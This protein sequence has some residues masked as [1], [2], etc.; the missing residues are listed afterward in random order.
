MGS[1]QQLEI[2][3]A[4]LFKSRQYSKVVFEIMSETA[5]EERSAFL[6]NL[7]GL[8]KIANNNKNKEALTSAL[9]DFK[10]GYLKEKET[11]HAIDGLAN[12]ITSSVFLIDLEKNYEFDFTEILDFYN[13]SERFCKNHRSIHL[14]MAMVY[15]RLN[16]AKKLI[17]HF[18]KVIESNKYNAIDLCNYG[19]WQC[20]DKA[21]NQ[22]D[23]FNYGKFLD[24][25]LKVFTRDQLVEISQASNSKIRIGF[26]S[27]DI[28][29]GH[30]I[31]YFLKTIISNYDKKKFEIILLLNDTKEDQLTENFKNLVDKTINISRF[32][33][34]NALNRIRE[35]NLDIIIDLMGYTSKQRIELFKNRMAKKQIIWM[36]YCN[37]TGLENMDYIIADQNLIRPDEEKFYSE[38]VIYL[39]KI[40]NTHCGFDFE[41]KENPPPF[42]KNNYFTFGSFNNFDKI[43]D[44]V[45]YI[46]SKILKKIDNSKLVLKT[47]SKRLATRRL[48][49]LFKKNNVLDSINFIDR[50]EKFKDH[51]DNYTQIDIAL[52]T[53]PYNG[54]TTSFEA[55]WMGVP[56]ITIAGYNFNSRCGESINKNL[57]MEHLIAKDEDDYVKKVVNLTNNTNDYIK[58]R[59]SIFLDA[60]K[61]PLFNK[62]DYSKSFFESLRKIVQ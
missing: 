25:N 35:L 34:I 43:N 41:R 37:T 19:Y 5:E 7:L 16:D 45:I 3:V 52:D 1:I 29:E 51:L 36:G 20:F 54:V 18:K 21:W 53:F 13:F 28:I 60:V 57:N 31:T 8:S 9:K 30:S 27:A 42:I 40:W 6:C 62:K 46:W 2:K 56:V 50:A 4:E 55:I 23:F 22:S 26:L 61:S 32:S 12:F 39:P 33:N 59:K 14:A 44:D 24:K 10:F 48:K 15:R 38:K 47:S 17:F 11:I 58:I 49:G